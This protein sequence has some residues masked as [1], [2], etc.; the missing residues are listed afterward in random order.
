MIIERAQWLEWADRF[1]RLTSQVR[2]NMK[3]Q[4]LAS[5]LLCLGL[6]CGSFFAFHLAI[7]AY[8]LNRWAGE[9]VGAK[10]AELERDFQARVPEEGSTDAEAIGRWAREKGVTVFVVSD[11]GLRPRSLSFLE[12][13]APEGPA[14]LHPT[15][16]RRRDGK[17]HFLYVPL[18]SLR[19]VSWAVS[20]LLAFDVFLVSLVFVLKKKLD[21]IQRIERGISVLE[22]GDL[23]HVIPVEGADEPARLAASINLLS[24]S[25]Q[26]RISSE[27]KALS[28]NR[29]IIGDLSHDIRTPLTVGM[30]YLTLLLE[31]EDLSERERREYLALALKKAEQI[32][33]RTRALLDFATLTSG[34]LP[35][36]RT[37]VDVRTMV[38]QLKEELSALAKLRVEDGLPEGA[39]LCGDVGLLERLF[40]N[41]LSNLQKHG[42]TT[43]PV[44][45]RARLRDGGVLLETENA[46]AGRPRAE[47][48]SLGL[49]IC[50]CILEL[51]GGR[52]ETERDG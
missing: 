29:E 26:D 18:R 25:I 40:D 6:S 20:L 2:E 51:H 7:R 19:F 1:S 4:L 46:I 39:T 3:L 30:G 13:I 12:G 28:A 42:D 21:Y 16:V 32:K 34:Q 52:L 41:L 35:V 47:S 48:S 23:D 44:I 22:S 45:F 36:H 9:D 31:K 17:V 38:D 8:R 24:R 33:E 37:V 11:D 10:L 27:Q 49:K 5:I 14:F 50:A 43:R 15:V